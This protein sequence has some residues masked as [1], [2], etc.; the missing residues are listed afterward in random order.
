[1][2]AAILSLRFYREYFFW[3]IV[4]VVII[5]LIAYFIAP[6]IISRKHQSVIRLIYNQFD[7][8]SS[9]SALHEK[10]TNKLHI[11]SNNFFIIIYNSLDF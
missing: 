7:T 5:V 8:Y 2:L 3:V 6:V 4:I 1:M 11:A 9:S 10:S